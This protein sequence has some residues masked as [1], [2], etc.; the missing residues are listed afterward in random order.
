MPSSAAM[1]ADRLQR[2][3]S[4]CRGYV[5]AGELSFS[6]VLVAMNGEVQLRDSYGY[7]DLATKAPIS[8]N[9]IVR[10]YSMTKPIVCAAA[11]VCFERGLF[12]M[13]DPVEVHLPEFRDMSVM[14]NGDLVEPKR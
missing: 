13:D 5:D 8:E 6:Q 3:K 14:E 12:L 11:L 2:L 4:M 1:D 9:A 7:S 10:L